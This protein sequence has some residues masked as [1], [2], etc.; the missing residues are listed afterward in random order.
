MNKFCRIHVWCRG[1]FTVF[2]KPVLINIKL[3]LKIKIKFI[4][5]RKKF[6]WTAKICS[7]IFGPAF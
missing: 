4:L 5:H 3:N 2:N 1:I 6:F 7:T